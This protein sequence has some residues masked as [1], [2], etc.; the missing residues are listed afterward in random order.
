MVHGRAGAC[1]VGLPTY[2]S[3][4]LYDVKAAHTDFFEGSQCETPDIHANNSGEGANCARRARKSLA[5]VAYRAQAA[6]LPASEDAYNT[7]RQGNRARTDETKT[8]YSRV[9]LSAPLRYEDSA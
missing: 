3:T 9:N 4:L 1:A 2:V 6:Q 8:W 7:P 5:A